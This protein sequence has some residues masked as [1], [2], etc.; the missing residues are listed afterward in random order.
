MDM[1]KL[2][3]HCFYINHVQQNDA[4]PVGGGT[5][6]SVDA[7]WRVCVD[8]GTA[9]T[10]ISAAADEYTKHYRNPAWINWLSERAPDVDPDLMVN[11]QSF[12]AAIQGVRTGQGQ[13]PQDRNAMYLKAPHNTVSLTEVYS[14]ANAMCVEMALLGKM[15][16]D[17]KRVCSSFYS[18]ETLVGSAAQDAHDSVPHSFLVLKSGGQEYVFD[19]ALPNMSAGGDMLALLNPCR[20]LLQGDDLRRDLLFVECED[21]LTK[22][23]RYYG[24]G[25]CGGVPD[26]YVVRKNEGKRSQYDGE[27][28]IP[29]GKGSHAPSAATCRRAVVRPT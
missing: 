15:Y 16:L 13:C 21:V 27:P 19:A 24:V 10:K 23:K 11:V 6:G 9:F 8:Y 26:S 7:P 28:N 1:T 29:E 2:F 4:V 22:Q 17:T 12:V 3:N 25:D 18:G 5:V 14:S 20:S